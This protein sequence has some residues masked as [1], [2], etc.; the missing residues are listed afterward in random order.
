MESFPPAVASTASAAPAVCSSPCCD[1]SVATDED[2]W[3][4]SSSSG[5]A[6]AYPSSVAH[7][8]TDATYAARACW[9]VGRRPRP[10]SLM[11]NRACAMPSAEGGMAQMT[12]AN[13][14][15]IT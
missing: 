13:V 1:S 6:A 11:D 2:S 8:T 4:R 7:S 14:F 10:P 5:H 15:S 12:L 9:C 3:M